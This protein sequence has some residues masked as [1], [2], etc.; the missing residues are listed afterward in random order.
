V[1][2]GI[3]RAKSSGAPLLHAFGIISYED[4]TTTYRMRAFNE[5]RFLETGIRLLE[6]GKRMTWGFTLGEVR[7]KSLLRINEH[8]EWTEVHEITIG[9]KPPR[10]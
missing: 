6:E 4:E 7:T 5:G 8:D 10:N 1:I 3:G 2:E 9:S